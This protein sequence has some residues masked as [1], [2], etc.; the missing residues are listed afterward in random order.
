MYPQLVGWCLPGIPCS[1]NNIFANPLAPAPPSHLSLPHI[2]SHL[3]RTRMS[4]TPRC[5][6][7]TTISF[8]AARRCHFR[9]DL[10]F[11]IHVP[12]WFTSLFNHKTSGCQS[13]KASCQPVLQFAFRFS[14]TWGT[15]MRQRDGGGR[16]LIRGSDRHFQDKLSDGGCTFPQ[17][18]PIRP[19]W[20][21][22]GSESGCVH[23]QGDVDVLHLIDPSQALEVMGRQGGLTAEPTSRYTLS[24]MSLHTH[25]HARL[26]QTTPCGLSLM[27][28]TDML[29][30]THVSW[31]TCTVP[32]GHP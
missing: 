13:D 26:L 19:R 23:V 15:E 12:G 17:W 30:Q 1:K 6:Q 3:S 5:H 2:H 21:D 8:E 31:H 24:H 20:G 7:M 28:Y 16:R 29:R 9:E 10:L 32:F 18:Y 22:G 14:Y 11:N 25:K 4:T 27:G